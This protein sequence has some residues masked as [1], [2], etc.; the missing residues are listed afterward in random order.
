MFKNGH[1]R[2]LMTLSGLQRLGIEEDSDTSWIVPSTLFADQIKQVIELIKK[3]EFCPP[4]FDD[5]K[6]A[7]DFIRR[8]PVGTANYRKAA[9]GPTPMNKS[10]ALKALKKT[11]RRRRK[12]DTEDTEDNG[13]T[14]EQLAARRD[15]K[16]VRELEKNRKIKSDL[17]IH[18]SDEEDDP[19]KDRIFFEQERK[20]REKSN[21]I[22]MKELLGVGKEKAMQSRKRQS[23]AM[24]EVSDEGEE[25]TLSARNKHP[26]AISVDSDDEVAEASRRSS[27]VAARDNIL[28]EHGDD[29][30][31]TPMS[32]PHIRSS[33]TKRRRISSDD[34]SAS[35]KLSAAEK[36]L[37]GDRAIPDGE[38][39]DIVP[40]ARP[41]RQRVRAGFIADT[42]DEDDE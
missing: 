11:R 12:D 31:D 26:R 7:G 33:P 30:T 2:L 18:D 23:S 41:A 35:P 38:D 4:V 14:E 28:A 22:I 17:F 37:E 5:G 15:T 36:G 21:I 1:L 9:G 13:L 20:L 39:E 34:G 40:V 29:T 8:K 24:S 42:S 32:S 3:Y 25:I 10:D 6:E 16:R 19:E 27:S